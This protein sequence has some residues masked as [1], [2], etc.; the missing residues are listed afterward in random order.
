MKAQSISKFIFNKAEYIIEDESGSLLLRIDYFNN[1]YAI[2]QR[3]QTV[4]K[5]IK[6]EAKYIAEDLLSRKHGKNFAEKFI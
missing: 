2:E 6:K 4:T 3:S 1:S 5:K